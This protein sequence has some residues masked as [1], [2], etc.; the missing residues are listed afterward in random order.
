MKSLYI[1][2]EKGFDEET[3]TW[4][5]TGKDSQGRALVWPLAALLNW[6]RSA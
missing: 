3:S 6:L 5:L 2:Y 1:P 4:T